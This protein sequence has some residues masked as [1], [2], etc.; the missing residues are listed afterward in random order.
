MTGNKIEVEA[1]QILIQKSDIPE[2]VKAT[3][4][5]ALNV[6]NDQGEEVVY[7]SVKR[8]WF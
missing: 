1:I 4:N 5:S 6:C 7:N 8:V 3:A 2:D